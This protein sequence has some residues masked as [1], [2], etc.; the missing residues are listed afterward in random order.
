[1]L[2]SFI[3]TEPAGNLVSLPLHD[4]LLLLSLVEA[5]VQ[6]VGWCWGRRLGSCK[7]PC[8]NLCSGRDIEVALMGVPSLGGGLCS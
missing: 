1:M 6:R 3:S 5:V 7:C 4:S 8:S 2:H